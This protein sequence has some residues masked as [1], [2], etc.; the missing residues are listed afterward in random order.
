MQSWPTAVWKVSTRGVL[1]IEIFR[2][3]VFLGFFLFLTSF[4]VNCSHKL[5]FAHMLSAHGSPTLFWQFFFCRLSLIKAAVVYFY[6]ARQWDA[7]DAFVAFSGELCESDSF[8][9]WQ[10]APWGGHKLPCHLVVWHSGRRRITT[11]PPR[12]PTS[13]TSDRSS[14][15]EYTH[16]ENA[17]VLLS[18]GVSCSSCFW[19]RGILWDIPGKRQEHLENVHL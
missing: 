6:D 14:S 17:N 11:A 5:H 16:F 10:D 8:M 18:K 1:V 13:M 3:D 4:E 9:F 15:R 2:D 7:N 19:Q 12:W